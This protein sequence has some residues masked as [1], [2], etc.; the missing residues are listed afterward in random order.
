MAGGMK[1]VIDSVFPLAEFEQGLARI[2]GRKVFG[3]VIVTL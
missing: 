2:E 1:P 3:K